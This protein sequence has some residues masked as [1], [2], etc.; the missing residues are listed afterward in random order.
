MLV[1]RI[2]EQVILPEMLVFLCHHP[3][4]RLDYQVLRVFSVAT[5]MFVLLFN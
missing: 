2:N 5:V 1:A 3:Q 4:A